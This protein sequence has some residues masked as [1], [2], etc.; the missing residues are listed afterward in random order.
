MKRELLLRGTIKE[1]LSPKSD[2]ATP[3]GTKKRKLFVKR[4]PSRPERDDKTEIVRQEVSEPR[5]EGQKSGNCSLRGIRA[6]PRG[7][8]KEK[9]SV[10]MRFF[11]I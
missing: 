4:C 9:S 11:S 3:R 6:P 1:K 8:K 2:G 5:R 7:T 10:K